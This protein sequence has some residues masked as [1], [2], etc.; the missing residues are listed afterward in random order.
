MYN[1]RNVRSQP[2]VTVKSSR[3]PLESGIVKTRWGTISPGHII[4]GI[5]SALQETTLAVQEVIDVIQ[6]DKNITKKASAK[7]NLGTISNVGVSTLI[8]DLAEVTLYQASD[9]PK[10]GNSGVWNNSYIPRLYYIKDEPFEM[11]S[12]ELLGGIDGMVTLLTFN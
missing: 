7:L 6:K 5:A 3:C 11:T 9:K 4:A 8:G 12:A 1:Y 2:A 10:I